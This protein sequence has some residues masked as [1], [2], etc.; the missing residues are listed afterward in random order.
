MTVGIDWLEVFGEM[1]ITPLGPLGPGVDGGAREVASTY[2]A[3]GDFGATDEVL[4]KKRKTE[5]WP[6][7]DLTSI[8]PP[9]SSVISARSARRS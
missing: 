4:M 7:S 1:S 5:P 9:S 8:L 2:W 3:S 6:R